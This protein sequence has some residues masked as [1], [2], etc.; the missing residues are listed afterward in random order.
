MNVKLNYKKKPFAHQEKALAT[1]DGKLEFG[2]FMEMGTGKSKVL[3]DELAILHLQKKINFALIIAP[4]GVYSNWVRKEIPEHMSTDI[5][6]RTIQYFSSANKS[7]L[8]HMRSVGQQFDGLTLFVMNVESFS[9]VKGQ[10]TGQYLQRMF[11]K[12]GLIAID[13]STTIKNHKAKRTKAL[14]KI[15]KNF[16]YRRILTGSP[17]TKSPVDIFSQSEFLRP[18]LLGFESFY[19]F[20]NKYAIMETGY[21]GYHNREYS[22]IVGFRNLDDL[23]NRLLKWSYRA[24]KKD[25]LDLPDKLYTSRNVPLTPEQKRMY[26]SIEEEA[27]YMFESG[28]LTTAP[29]IITQMLRLQQVLSG[30]LRTEQGELQTFPTYRIDALQEILN[31]HDGKAIIFSRFRYDIENI[32]KNLPNAG[33]YYGATTDEERQLLIDEF[34]NPDG[35]IQYFVGN[36]QTA[37]YG[38]TLTQANLIIYY[39]NDFNLE[40]RMQSEDRA[41]RIGQTKNVTYV[42]LITPNTIDQKIVEALR[43]KIELGA[44]VLGEKAREWLR[45][46]KTKHNY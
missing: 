1:A 8:E 17:I 11:G 20:Q 12:Y 9:T 45:L 32:V 29:A 33:A 13:E 26:K 39:A 15:S 28:D 44:K 38:L 37:G 31:E 2:Y 14:L 42:D 35:N 5:S 40:T 30:H 22:T 24:L 36:P 18:G 21:N 6:H 34:Q 4:K 43:D 27:Y 25:C 16:A 19:G 7:Q 41:H 10:K 23:S 46:S 3:I